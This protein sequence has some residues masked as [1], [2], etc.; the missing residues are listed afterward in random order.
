MNRPSI[1]AVASVPASLRENTTSDHPFVR[2]VRRV[3][4]LRALTTEG[5]RMARAARDAAR[6]GLVRDG[7]AADRSRPGKG[8]S[9]RPSHSDYDVLRQIR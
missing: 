8:P 5:R 6:L 1:A 9:R 4:Q 2:L 3:A 7:V